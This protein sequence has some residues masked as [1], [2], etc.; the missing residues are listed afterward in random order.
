MNKT[1]ISSKREFRYRSSTKV[2]KNHP[3]GRNISETYNWDLDK[4]IESS[5]ADLESYLAHAPKSKENIYIA[6]FKTY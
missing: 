2:K 1:L 4:K 5:S 3:V 6:Q